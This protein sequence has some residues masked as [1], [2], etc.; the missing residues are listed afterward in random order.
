MYLKVLVSYYSIGAFLIMQS[1]YYEGS[2]NHLK[3]GPC[4]E[5]ENLYLL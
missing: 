3:C 2:K 5:S 4:L 1:G